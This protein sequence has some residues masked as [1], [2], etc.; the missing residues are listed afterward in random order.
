MKAIEEF[1]KEYKSSDVITAY[2]KTCEANGWGNPKYNDYFSGNPSICVRVP[3]GGGKTIIAASAIKILDEGTI[4]TGAPLVLWLTPSEAI[5]TQTHAA[6]NDP[7]HPCR[8]ALE[9]QYPGKVQVCDLDSVFTLN[10]NNFGAD[11]IIVVSTIQAFNVEDTSI[12]NVYAYNENLDRFFVNIDSSRFNEA[13]D[14][15]E[16]KDISES[17]GGVLTKQDVGQAKHSLANLFRLRHPILIV[18]EAHN[19]R[20]EKFFT[21]LNRLEPSVCLELTAT[22][23]DKN[24]TI[25][26]VS[27]R[28]LKAESMIKM[29][30]LLTPQNDG[31]ENCITEAYLKRKELQEL[32]FKEKDYIRPLVLIQA[33]KKD[34]QATVEK[35]KDYLKNFLKVPEE[36]IAVYTGSDKD[37]KGKELF[38]KNCK[39]NYIITVQALKEGWDCSFAYILCGLQNIQNSK[40]TEQLLGRVLRM[41]YAK[42]RS[43]DEL[44]NAYAHICS[45]RTVE[46]AS[47][48]QDR[49]V[50][51]L[52]FDRLESRDILKSQQGTQPKPEPDTG[53]MPL[54]TEDN[55]SD[56]GTPAAAPVAKMILQIPTQTVEAVTKIIGIEDT[57]EV[58]E[59]RSLTGDEVSLI[60][61]KK[62]LTDDLVNQFETEVLKRTSKNNQDKVEESF[63]IFRHDQAE[64]RSFNIQK[65][66]PLKPIPNLLFEFEGE[67]RVLSG[68]AALSEGWDP[69]KFSIALPDYQ[70]KKFSEIFKLDSDA[71]G[72][73]QYEVIGKEEVKNWQLYLSDEFEQISDA[74]LINWLSREVRRN[75]VVPAQ[76]EKF[77]ELVVNYLTT[78]KDFSLNELVF[79]R[80][81][82]KNEISS[83]LDK[84]YKKAKEKGF[85][86]LLN[87]DTRPCPEGSDLSFKF[88]PEFYIPKRIYQEGNGARSFKKHWFPQIH[89]LRYKTEGGAVSEEYECAVAIDTLPE[90]EFWI[91]N[92]EKSEYS[93]RLPLAGGNFYPD[94]YVKLRDGRHLI[95][96]YKGEMLKGNDDTKEKLRVGKKYEEVNKGRV[97]FL[98]IT[99]TGE[100]ESISEQIKKKLSS[101]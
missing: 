80:F 56:G 64:N 15:V 82:L 42:R 54:F 59:R 63:K 89:D 92:I 1:L 70:P 66:F 83:L 79:D 19:N 76:M 33:E 72:K 50:E 88:T 30:I 98:M 60:Q 6:L 25:Y 26:S 55:G 28:E 10:P 90:V 58:V 99:K 100:G 43:T 7:A 68:E 101:R 65:K 44:N 8:Q 45:P 38:E 24:N 73:F 39:F 51:G 47:V 11:C 34:G 9:A 71:S 20:T 16:E 94:F 29:P 48:L 2:K 81:N 87:L 49:I 95:V 5:T 13:L 37:F 53:T 31:W 62:E 18:D 40:D 61:L 69:S 32:S 74:S 91:R 17:P 35:V 3:T 14:K 21:T 78:N 85:Q 12:R 41:P 57:V 23:Q 4:G 22:P 75:D 77:V 27:A 36:E 67:L 97:L 93:L 86:Q 46:L 84:N 96:E 52:G